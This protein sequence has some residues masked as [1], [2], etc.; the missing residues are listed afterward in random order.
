[1]CKLSTF[2]FPVSYHLNIVNL[3]MDCAHQPNK[4]KLK[5]RTKWMMPSSAKCDKASFM[6]PKQCT[7]LSFSPHRWCCLDFHSIEIFLNEM[8]FSLLFCAATGNQTQNICC[9]FERDLNSGRTIDWAT[10]AAASGLSNLYLP[11]IAKWNE[12]KP[13]GVPQNL[14]AASLNVSPHS[15]QIKSFFLLLQTFFLSCFL[16]LPLRLKLAFQCWKH[17]HSCS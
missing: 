10:A 15:L 5:F 3:I 13:I 11:K 8:K 17:R 7:Y 1:M 12:M 14:N 9:S 2:L 4:R 16:S 6:L